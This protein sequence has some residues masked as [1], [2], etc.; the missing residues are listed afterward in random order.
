MS[1]GTRDKQ[2]YDQRASDE[3]A[4]HFISANYDVRQ[5]LALAG[6]MLAREDHESG[7]AGQITGRAERPGT[8]WTARFG[9]GLDEV[10]ASS[11]LLVDDDLNPV[12]G[13][14]MPNPST[15][16][17]LWVY[18]ARPDVNCILHTHPPHIS[19][20]SMLGEEL[21]VAHMDTTMFF[22]DCAY[23]P[24]WP[25]VPFGDEEGEIIA[26]ALGQKHAI[27]L[28]HHGQL[29][30]CGTVEEAAVLAVFMERAA[31]MQLRARAVGPI[32]PIRPELAREA[33]Q[34]R[35]K[36]KAIEATF[37]YFARQI[38]RDQGD[39]AIK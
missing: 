3:M 10:T 25:G 15:R 1:E 34:Y 16:F 19:A 7:L 27:L 32:K 36:P 35:L 6:R 11:L 29:V 33:R 12:E 2:F 30:A 17:H 20:L 14:G 8:F 24:E 5:K 37:N 26:N 13:D 9:Y 31:K 28:A 38:L 39:V 4:Q 23:L 22:E 18:R 21:A